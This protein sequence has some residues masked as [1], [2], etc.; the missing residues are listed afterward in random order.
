MGLFLFY[1]AALLA[2]STAL[3]M[4]AVCGASLIER[5]PNQHRLLA[6][7]LGSKSVSGTGGWIQV[8]E[9]GIHKSAENQQS[10]YALPNRHNYTVRSI[11]CYGMCFLTQGVRK[12]L[13]YSV[14]LQTRIDFQVGRGLLNFHSKSSLISPL[15][16]M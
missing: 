7:T 12:V 6:N 14:N 4:K 13:M 8:S 11:S 15:H 5:L 10:E 16:F 2:V 3:H 1:V 9:H